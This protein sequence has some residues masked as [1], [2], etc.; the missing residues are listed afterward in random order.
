MGV[1]RL[2]EKS[3]NLFRRQNGLYR[4]Y[5]QYAELVL[6]VEMPI[7]FVSSLEMISIILV[8]SGHTYVAILSFHK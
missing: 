8:K 2:H 1:V 3:H 4:P 7:C 6:L 5:L